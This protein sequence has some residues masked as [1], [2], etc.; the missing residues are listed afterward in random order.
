MSTLSASQLQIRQQRLDQQRI[1][2][3]QFATPQEIVAWMGAVQGQDYLGTKWALGLRMQNGTD[4][5]LEQAFNEG[6]ILR[7][8]VMRPTWH[9]V[10]PADIR[11]ILELTAPRVQ[12]LM[13]PY[14][15]QYGLDEATLVRSNDVIAKALAGGRFLTRAEL[16]TALAEEG[17]STNAMRLGFIM[18]HAE[19]DAIVCSGPRRGKQFT[20]ALL[21]ERAPQA[22]SLPRAEALAELTRR[23]FTSHGPATV[24]DFAWWSGL[25]V[26]DA[27]AGLAMVT[28]HL[29]HEEIDGQNYWFSASASTNPTPLAA[30]PSEAAFLL[31]TFDE[32]L[33]GFRSFDESRRGGGVLVFESTIV[34]GGKVMGSWKRTFKK[35]GV[36]IELAPFSPLND[37][38]GEAVNAA[39]QRY[40]EFMAMPVVSRYL[41]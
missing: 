31:P 39:A 25:T 36:V 18:G 11:W 20:Y 15:R 27:K 40:G 1:T 26:A 23:Y 13:A 33:V 9:F 30:A 32:F 21:D 22:K 2:Q 6:R 38:E 3:N 7:T 16:G 17:I 37:D 4:D 5:A 28:S 8:H 24:H 41:N 10:T 12:A 19:L 14:Y 34:I 35:G 29:H